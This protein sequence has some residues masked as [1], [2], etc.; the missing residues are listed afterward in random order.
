M[1]LVIVCSAAIALDYE[2]DGNYHHNQNDNV[3]EADKAKSS[4]ELV[5]GM[6]GGHQVIPPQFQTDRHVYHCQNYYA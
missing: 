1:C 4:E 2:I 5:I 3:R 6:H